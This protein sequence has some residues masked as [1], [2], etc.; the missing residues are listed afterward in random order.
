MKKK[1]KKLLK[2]ENGPQFGPLAAAAAQEEAAKLK[3]TTAEAKE[4]TNLLE[5]DEE[6]KRLKQEALELKV[7]Y[8]DGFEI[9]KT[10]RIKKETKIG[11]FQEIC[12][13][14]FIDE[15]PDL[16]SI[17]GEFGFLFVVDG[18]IIPT[19]LTFLDVLK[20]DLKGISGQP[21]FRLL[22]REGYEERIGEPAIIIDKRVYD[23]S[24]HIYPLKNW[25]QLNMALID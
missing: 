20:K 15:Y 13:R 10:L 1:K 11:F 12:R 18:V 19:S 22:K 6:T 3:T 4:R 5:D 21:L 2:Q 16:K 7:K 14:D 8:W 25:N 9:I 17:R 24:K 23:S